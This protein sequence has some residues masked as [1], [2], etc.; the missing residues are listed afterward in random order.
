MKMNLLDNF[1]IFKNELDYLKEL[2]KNK[3][4]KLF[5]RFSRDFIH[6]NQYIIFFICLF[7]NIMLLFEL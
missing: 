6:F 3:K 1:E 5:K 7:I 4:I 2:S